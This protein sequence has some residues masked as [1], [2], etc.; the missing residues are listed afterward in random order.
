MAKIGAQ[1]STKV[2]HINLVLLLDWILDQLI[3]NWII[4]KWI[5]LNWY[6]K[7]SAPNRKQAD[8]KNEVFKH[9]E[10]QM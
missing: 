9:F 1:V 8:L 4:L 10:L 5:I 2:E 6:A 7:F 3:L